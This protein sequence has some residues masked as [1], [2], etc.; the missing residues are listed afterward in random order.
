MRAIVY[1]RAKGE[2]ETKP[3]GTERDVYRV[4]YEW[5]AHALTDVGRLQ[6]RNPVS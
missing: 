6:A 5:A 2:L 4:G 1:Q 3:F